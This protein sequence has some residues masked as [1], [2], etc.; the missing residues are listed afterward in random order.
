MEK[1]PISIHDIAKELI[2]I[3]FK[4]YLNDPLSI[5]ADYKDEEKH[6]NSYRGRQLLEMLQNADDAAVTDKEKKALIKIQHNTL[7]IANNGEPFNRDG[8]ESILYSNLSQKFEKKNQIGNKGLGFKSVLSWA[9]VV[10]IKSYD[11]KISFSREHSIKFLKNL[12]KANPS[13]ATEIKR[14][15]KIKYPIPILRC[16]IIQKEIDLPAELR[17]YDTIIKLELKPGVEDDIDGQF[18]VLPIS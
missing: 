5:V 9:N 12:I 2:D 7:Y 14:K 3:R 10:S 17:E 6:T 15:T 4:H 8:L 16:P 1:A 13:V 11:L 18:L